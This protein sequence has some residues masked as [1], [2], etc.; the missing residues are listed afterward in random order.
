MASE[1]REAWQTWRPVQRSVAAAS[2]APPATVAQATA[3]W[4]HRAQIARVDRQWSIAELAAHVRCDVE[5][6]AA[7]ERGD[8]L[9]DEPVRRR[10]ADALGI[11]CS[12]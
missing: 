4:R 3:S 12:G 8:A 9:L 1:Y 10:L 7:F 11:A 6:L 5:T 2:A